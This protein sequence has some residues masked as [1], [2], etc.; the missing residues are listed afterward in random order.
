MKRKLISLSLMIVLIFTLTACGEKVEKSSIE[1]V[2]V[3]V[4]VLEFIDMVGREIVLNGPRDKVLAIGS[5]L[6]MYTYVNGT[7][8][9]VGVE[10]SQ[11]NLDSG[12]P[13]ILANPELTE[14][15]IVGEGFPSEVDPELVILADP[16]IIIAGDLDIKT[17][18]ELEKKTGIPVIAVTCGRLAVFDE[19]MYESIKMIGMIVDKEE[20][21]NEVVD[22]L[23]SSKEELR[24]LTK[25]IPEDGKPSI[26]MGA[27]SYNGKHGIE[28]T[29][30]NSPVL[31]AVN[32]KNVADE[33][34][35]DGPITIDRE[36][37]IK[38]DPDIII[39]DENGLSLVKED[40]EKNPGYY[41]SLSAFKNGKVYGQL[42][43]VSYHSNIETAL[44]DTYFIGSILYPEVFTDIDPIK[45]ADEIYKFMLGQELY[46]VM[47]D[48]F[49]GY[50]KIEL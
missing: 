48:K 15:D 17:I 35:T 19:N 6:R 5:S 9:L 8:R 37:L 21:A 20:R 14:L 7:D 16:D 29:R 25:G 12:R 28:S 45:K 39:I 4:E 33:I 3:D 11:Q 27:L 40:Y 22:Y 44:A 13:Y 31:N 43:Y 47:A 50:I 36:Q 41:N 32:A 2:A 1:E 34:E 38:W 10:T 49:G 30:V 23:I 26:Y 24:E 42:P 46:G 18:E